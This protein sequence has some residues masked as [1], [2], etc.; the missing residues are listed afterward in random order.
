MVVN[1]APENDDA[2]VFEG[3]RRVCRALVHRQPEFVWVR[4]RIDV[5]CDG[6]AVREL[7]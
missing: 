6:I 5:M 4:E 7:H 2:A 1:I 3:N